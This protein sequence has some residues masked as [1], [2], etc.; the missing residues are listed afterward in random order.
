MDAPDS[1][2]TK[3]GPAE[4]AAIERIAV[5]RLGHETGPGVTHR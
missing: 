1:F 4:R 2:W 5:W 3:L